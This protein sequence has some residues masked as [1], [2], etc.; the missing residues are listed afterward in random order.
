MYRSLSPHYFSVED[1]FAT[2]ERLPCKFIVPVH[3]LG[4]DVCIT[5]LLNDCKVIVRLLNRHLFC[6]HYQDAAVFI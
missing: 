1:I 2:Q 5:L 3:R 4:K 6:S